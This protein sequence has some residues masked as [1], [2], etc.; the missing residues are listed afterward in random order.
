MSLKYNTAQSYTVAVDSQLM[1]H[2]SKTQKKL[3]LGQLLFSRGLL[4]KETS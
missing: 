1:K 2:A 4:H 3:E